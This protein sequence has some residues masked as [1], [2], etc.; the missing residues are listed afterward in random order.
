MENLDDKTLE[1]MQVKLLQ[2]QASLLE[3]GGTV[4]DTLE[5]DLEDL[6]PLYTLAY[7]HYTAGNYDDANTLFQALC[8]YNHADFRFWMGLAGTRQALGHLGIAIDAYTMAGLVAKMADPTPFVYGCI[9]HMKLGNLQEAKGG[10]EGAL[11]LGNGEA[12]YAAIL[13]KA[14][15]LLE[16]VNAKLL[17]QES[18][19]SEV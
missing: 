16:S 19:Q 5:I 11:L 13:Q 3:V 1:E 7:N 4:A 12:Q 6:E 9:C 14:E 17:E 8:L 15:V 18:S 10:L 2:A